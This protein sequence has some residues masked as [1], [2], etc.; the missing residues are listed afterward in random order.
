MRKWTRYLSS[1]ALLALLCWVVLPDRPTQA[2]VGPS[3]QILCNKLASATLTGTGSTVTT[4]LMSGLTGQ[5]IVICGWHVT[6][7]GTTAGTFQ[8]EYGTQG[9]PCTSPTVLTPAFSV[10]ST[11]PATDHID[12]ASLSVPKSSATQLNQLCLVTTGAATSTLQIGIWFA[13]LM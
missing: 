1:L 8:L 12:Y 13:V 11:A 3:N 4:S 10:S 9:G 7:S 6:Q 5:T 2:Q